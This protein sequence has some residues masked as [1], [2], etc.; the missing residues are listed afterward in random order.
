MEDAMTSSDMALIEE[1]RKDGEVNTEGT[2]TYSP[3]PQRLR[4]RMK[5]SILDVVV[6]ISYMIG[7]TVQMAT[8][9]IKTLT[10]SS[11]VPKSFEAAADGMVDY[12]SKIEKIGVKSTTVNG[13][14]VVDG[15]LSP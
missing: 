13:D 10:K 9:F 14:D 3:E 4:T 1:E 11:S 6:S 7:G 8:R 2:E 5:V 15:R 12:E